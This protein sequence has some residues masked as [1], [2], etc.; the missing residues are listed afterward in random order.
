MSD[1]PTSKTALGVQAYRWLVAACMG[2]LVLL[3]QRQLASI[4]ETASSVRDLKAQMM[5]M[6]GTT[7]SRFNAHAERLSAIDRRNDTQDTKIDGIWQRLWSF[8]TTPGQ[9]GNP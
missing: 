8:Q 5:T 3:S 7:E 6:Q 1:V 9:R 2:I 4:D